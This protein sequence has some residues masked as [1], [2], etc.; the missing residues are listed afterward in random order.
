MLINDKRALAYSARCG[1]VSPIEGADRIE[2]MEVLG[3]RVIVK[4][5]EFSEGDLCVYFEIDSKL[6]EAPWSE[7]MASKHYKVKTMKLSKFNVISQGLALPYSA[8]EMELPNEEGVDL[9]EKLG[10]RYSVE[11]DNVRKAPSSGRD[12]KSMAARHQKLF[13]TKPIRWLMRHK[14]G[15]NILFALFGNAKKKKNWPEFIRK[16]DEERV[17]NMPWVLGTDTQY[18]VTEKLDGTSCSFGLKRKR[19]GKFE[20]YVCS[21]NVLQADEDQK[22]FHD[23]NI[24]WALAKKY[25]IKENLI[26]YLKENPKLDWVY[27]QGEG[28]GKVQGNPL[29]LNED[30]LYIFN[31]VRSD[32]GR[33]ASSIGKE[34]VNNWG[35][36]W[37]PILGIETLPETMEEM[38][39]LATGSSAVN[40]NVLREGLVY[41]GLDGQMSFKNVSREYLVSK[42]E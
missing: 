33:L 22:C 24:Y 21:R 3:W 18:V 38:K 14:Q 40:P 11:E 36:K 1:K 37:V 26:K 29:K 27:I 6:P 17:E 4:K 34:I 2:L 15:R 39:E 16:T 19:F 20:F 13:K 25:N 42:G 28:V 41:R 35:M 32:I 30:D 23:Y 12:Y 10:V 5:G 9:T 8:F 31:F 7:F